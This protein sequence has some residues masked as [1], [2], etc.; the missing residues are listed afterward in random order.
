[1]ANAKLTE[2]YNIYQDRS[3]NL[4]GASTLMQQVYHQIFQA[5]QQ[6]GWT[7]NARELK[8]VIHRATI[9]CEC[10]EIG[11]EHLPLRFGITLNTKSAKPTVTVEIGTSSEQVEKEMII[12]ALS[13][14]NNNCARVAE[15]LGISRKSLYN[16][17]YKYSIK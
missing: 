7:G 1:M 4:G 5:F 9:V 17:L 10:D 11:L 15:L 6:Y 14:E 16:K 2:D 12:Q 13:V 8:K 3:G